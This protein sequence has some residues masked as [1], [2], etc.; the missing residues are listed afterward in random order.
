MSTI[1]KLRLQQAVR[2]FQNT[3]KASLHSVVEFLELIFV[4]DI[5]IK[6]LNQ[7]G[8]HFNHS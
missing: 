3:A 1:R 4:V 2:L 7:L 5:S 6:Q 8:W